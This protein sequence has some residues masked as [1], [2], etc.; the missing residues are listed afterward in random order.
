MIF[1][2]MIADFLGISVPKSANVHL[3]LS[4]ATTAVNVDAILGGDYVIK[5][6]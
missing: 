5:N 4:Y 6:D 1:D 2:V 3:R